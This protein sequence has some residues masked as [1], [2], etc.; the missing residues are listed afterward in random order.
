MLDPENLVIEGAIVHDA[1]GQRAEQVKGEMKMEVQPRKEQTLST[2]LRDV[3]ATHRDT[4]GDLSRDEVP[5]RLQNYVKEYLRN[6]HAADAAQHG[7][8]RK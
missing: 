8:A 6:A 5:L 7:E 1:L 3:R 4:G 2:D